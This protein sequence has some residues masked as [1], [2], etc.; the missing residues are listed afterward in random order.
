MPTTAIN[1]FDDPTAIKIGDE[2]EFFTETDVKK[3]FVGE[4]FNIGYDGHKT[5]HDLRP[6]AGRENE[7]PDIRPTLVAR[8]T[9]GFIIHKLSPSN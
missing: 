6:I 4:V 7:F 2:V 1:P 5:F 8:V 3:I 9:R